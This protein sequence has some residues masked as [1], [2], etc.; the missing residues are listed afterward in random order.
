[1]SDARLALRD[2]EVRA[3]LETI[4]ARF[5]YDF[6]SYARASLL[7]RIATSM[8][9]LGC[10]TPAELEAR[11]AREP[12]A[13]AAVLETLTVQVSDLFRDPAYFEY[14]RRNIVP[15]LRTYPFVRVWVAGCSSGEEAYS[16]AVVLR[17]EGLLERA[18]VYATDISPAALEQAQSGVYP[19]Q[20]MAAFTENHA[21]S[22]ATA[23]LSQ[24][25]AAAYARAVF[26]RSLREKIVFS[27]HSLA[28]DSVFA[29]VQVVSCRNV[30]IYFDRGLQ[31]RA[32]GL[33]RE[34]LPRRGF[35]GLGTKESLHS[36]AEGA[37][38]EEL[39]RGL[40]WFRR[41]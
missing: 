23:S 25:Y 29:E 34:A 38:F 2:E 3:L 12:D 22:G 20:R 24:H 10:A 17:E 32:V 13:F 37:H 35:L 28:T 14:F 30:L 39:D 21:R 8:V 36:A 19:L 33:F 6:R 41:R 9:R 4:Y 11:L 7:R 5:H 26:D 27:D 15:E 16:F 31:N 18:L 40:R 1:M